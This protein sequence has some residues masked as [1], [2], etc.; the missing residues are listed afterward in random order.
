MTEKKKK[1]SSAQ[2]AAKNR[3]NAKAYDQIPFR[4]PKGRREEL[5]AIAE[6]K[7]LSLNG[8]IALAIEKF[9]E[10]DYLNTPL[11]IVGRSTQ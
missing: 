4:V 5:K 9:L 10:E 3:Y 7:G 8:M 1:S 6:S 2:T 11:K